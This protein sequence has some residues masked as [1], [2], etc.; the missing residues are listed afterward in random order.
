MS[1]LTTKEF[2]KTLFIKDLSDVVASKPYISFMVMA[3]GIEF[4]GKCVNQN[5]KHWN[6]KNNS[7]A[8]FERAIKS[9]PSLQKYGRFLRKYR[10]YTTF[11]CGLLH[12]AAPH[13]SITL[14]SK[15]EAPHLQEKSGKLNL[16]AEDFYDDFRAACEYVIEKKFPVTDKAELVFLHVSSIDKNF[17]GE[18][19]INMDASGI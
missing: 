15:N 19:I 13:F 11:R 5:T 18:E 14:S 8:D 4:L 17:P 6:V 3:V 10:L 16:K 12:S 1:K 2:I 7:T 9:I